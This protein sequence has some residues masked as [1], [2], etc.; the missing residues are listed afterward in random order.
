MAQECP[1]RKQHRQE[2]RQTSQHTWAQIVETGAK[3]N[4]TI[5]ESP[6]D[7]PQIEQVTTDFLQK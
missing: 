5:G 7:G 6:I 3:G 2:I 1:K 4:V